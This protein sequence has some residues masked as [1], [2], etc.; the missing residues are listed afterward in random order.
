MNKKT[1]IMMMVLSICAVTQAAV[2]ETVS[3]QTGSAYA[4]SDS[5]LLQEDGVVITTTGYD[6]TTYPG[7]GSPDPVLTDGYNGG[8]LY[9]GTDISYLVLEYGT[10]DDPNFTVQ[11]DLSLTGAEFG[12]DLTSIETFTGWCDDRVGQKYWVEVS[13]VGSDE[14]TTLASVNQPYDAQVNTAMRI[15]LTDST[16]TLASGVDSIRFNFQQTGESPP[17][18]GSVWREVDVVGTA[19]IPEPAVAT[20]IGLVGVG[21]LVVRRIFSM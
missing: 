21:A 11:Y 19:A 18:D 13:V 9:E 5:D 12:Y 17:A 1:V 14:F 6:N 2:V 3:T 16:G 15:A 8:A 4:V 10:G 7:I 20:L